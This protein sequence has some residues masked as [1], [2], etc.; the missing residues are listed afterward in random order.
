M[1]VKYISEPRVCVGYGLKR[2]LKNKTALMS[3]GFE[4]SG[5]LKKYTHID[6]DKNLKIKKTGIEFFVQ[7]FVKT[8][9]KEVTE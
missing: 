4:E 7:I 9:E 1:I 5:E 8:I 3:E 2:F 6:T